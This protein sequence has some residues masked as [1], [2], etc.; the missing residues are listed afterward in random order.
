MG[1]SNFHSHNTFRLYNP[2]TKRVFHSRDVKWSQWNTVDQKQSLRKHNNVF[3]RTAVDNTSLD[4]AQKRNFHQ[5]IDHYLP[6]TTRMFN[7]VQDFD[8]N[9]SVASLDL[10]FDDWYPASDTTSRDRVPN[11]E[12]EIN[13]LEPQEPHILNQGQINENFQHFQKF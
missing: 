7:A 4:S 6:P 9:D 13:L 8:H 10:D 2:I 11:Q 5:L 3:M 12:E 1:Y